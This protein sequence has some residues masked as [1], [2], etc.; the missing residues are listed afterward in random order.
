MF[1]AGIMQESRERCQI[2]LVSYT[3]AGLIGKKSISI[4]DGN[5]YWDCEIGEE[6]STVKLS[7]FMR[8]NYITHIDSLFYFLVS[9]C[10]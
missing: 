10:S 3:F 5:R 8:D 6:V 2:S 9:L 4:V 1:L 7:Y